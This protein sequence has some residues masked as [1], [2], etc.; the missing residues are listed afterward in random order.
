MPQG[1]GL[2]RRGVGR[3]LVIALVLLAHGL[4]LLG[5]LRLGVWRDRRAPERQ[6][7]AVQM[8]LLR[9]PAPA[10]ADT[11]PPAVPRRPARREPQPITVAPP[12]PAPITESAPA[13]P[14]AITVPDATAASA[15][16]PAS[17]PTRL[18]L[19]LPRRAPGVA[20][21]NPALDDP[22]ANTARP[23]TVESR[24]AALLGG[25]DG[26]VEERLDDG[27]MRFRRGNSCV[28]VHPNRAERIDPFNASSF[29]KMRG[30]E[31]C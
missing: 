7:P 21:R 16:P 19:R 1:P 17:A 2:S 20:S 15:E 8:L 31:G 22:R 10:R 29:P 25:V 11:P 6:R 23:P 24:I 9:P 30:V 28:V 5:V 13:A 14:T 18:D 12:L 27:R 3:P 4:V 26:I